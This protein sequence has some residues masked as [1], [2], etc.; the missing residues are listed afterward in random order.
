M[1]EQTTITGSV[2]D[3]RRVKTYRFSGEF[4]TYKERLSSSDVSVDLWM[5]ICDGYKRRS[6]E[7]EVTLNVKVSA[8][9][10]PHTQSAPYIHRLYISATRKCSSVPLPVCTGSGSVLHCVIW[11]VSSDVF[12]KHVISFIIQRT[13][14]REESLIW[15]HYLVTSHP[16]GVIILCEQ[17][18]ELAASISC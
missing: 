9:G 14:R 3:W 12:I 16:P 13:A 6:Q 10:R 2:W 7:V 15:K 5:I 8:L 4:W 11:C 18:A 1:D 17:W